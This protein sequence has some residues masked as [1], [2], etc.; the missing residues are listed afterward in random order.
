M[1]ACQKCKIFS[2]WR[3]FPDECRRSVR[4]HKNILEK[5]KKEVQPNLPGIKIR[6]K[7]NLAGG[8]ARRAVRLAEGRARRVF[9]GLHLPRDDLE[10]PDTAV[11]ETASLGSRQWFG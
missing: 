1:H 6:K 4:R 3:K 2:E 7:R 11:G 8:D 5:K 10:R 9:A